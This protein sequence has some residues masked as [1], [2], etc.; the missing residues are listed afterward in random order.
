MV[1]V[2]TI[3]KNYSHEMSEKI[4]TERGRKF[5]PRRMAIVEPV[6][7]NIRTQKRLDQFTLRGKLK[8]NIQWLLYCIVHNMEKIVNFGYGFAAT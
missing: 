7:A 6:F 3:G 8:V 4:D 5:Y 2:G 1:P